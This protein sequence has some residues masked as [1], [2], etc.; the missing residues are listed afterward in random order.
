M[1]KR[2]LNILG[3][4]ALGQVSNVIIRVVSVPI[5]LHFWGENLYGEWLLLITIPSYLAISGT[6]IGHVAANEMDIKVSKGQKGEALQIFQSAWVFVTIISAIFIAICSLVAA[7]FPVENWLNIHHI[8]HVDV[9]LSFVLLAVYTVFSLQCELLVAV[10][11]ASGQYARG[12][13]SVNVILFAEFVGLIVVVMVSKS[14]IL[15]TCVNLLIRLVGMYVM[16][17]HLKKKVDW[18]HFGVQHASKQ[19]IRSSLIPTFAFIGFSLGNAITLQGMVTVIG[20]RLGPTAVVAYSVI[21]T[22]INFVKQLTSLIYYSVWPEF[23]AA[24]AKNDIELARK[25]H[26]SICQVTLLLSLISVVGLLVAGKSILHIWTGGKLQIDYIFFALMLISIV[27]NTLWL[28]SSF[29]EIS[30]NK[31]ERIALAYVISSIA[32]ILVAFFTVRT[33]GLRGLPVIQM[34]ADTIMLALVLRE[35]LSYVNDTMGQFARSQF[36]FSHIRKI[37]RVPKG[38]ISSQ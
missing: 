15:A 11:R 9:T 21:R 37:I 34:V 7:V 26:R 30:I 18:F 14:V 2:I 13:L 36:R 24:L 31:H 3:A 4:N 16:S 33:V 22:L 38:L 25:L 28:A 5:F 6:G 29:V 8:S 35:S 27:P 19:I 17:A 1:L 20:I 32:T 12:L 10:Y 23:S